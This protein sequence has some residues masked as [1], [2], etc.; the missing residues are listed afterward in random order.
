[1]TRQLQPTSRFLWLCVTSIISLALEDTDSLRLCSHLRS[2][3]RTRALPLLTVAGANQDLEVSRALE[4]GVNDYIRTPVETSEL[5]ARIRTQ[6]RRKRYNDCLRDSVQQTIEMAVKDPLTGLNNRRY[7]DAHL[8]G[9]FDKAVTA[10][11]PLSVVMC[12]IDHFK[13]VNDTHG[14]DV[15]DE[16]IKEVANRIAKSIRNI[17]CVC[18]FGGEE[19]V[20]IMPDTALALAEVVSERIRQ[21]IEKHPVVA[22]SGSNIVPITMSMGVANLVDVSDSPQ[23]LLKRADLALYEAKQNGRNQVVT[24]AA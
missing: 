1:M 7:M 21:E 5:V 4:I 6:L 3:E 11:K 18:R 8:K 23:T 9:I 14:H 17:D 12:D 15:G 24:Q 19:F 2:L 20:I 22:A 10:N 16:V 13:A